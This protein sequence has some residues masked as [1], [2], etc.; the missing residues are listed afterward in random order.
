M[1]AWPV[2]G[3]DGAL[4]DAVV[5]VA[6]KRWRMNGRR[7]PALEED[8]LAA[9]RPQKGEAVVFLGAGLG[10]GVAAALRMGLPVAVVDK[11]AGLAEALGIRL[12]H[13]V[14]WCRHAD[15]EAVLAALTRWQMALGGPPLVPIVHPLYARLD[16]VFYRTLAEQLAASRNTRF[17]QRAR[18]PRL[19]GDTPRILLVASAYFLHGELLSAC[20]RLGYAVRAVELPSQEV[21]RQEFVEAIL[22]AV[23]E[24]RPHFALTVNHLGVDREGVLTDL[25]ARLELPLASWFVDDPHLIIGLYHSAVS[26]WVA[27]FTWDADTVESLRAMGFVHV[28]YLPLGTDPTRFVPQGT[29]RL[30]VAFVG[31]SMVHK[32]R[33]RQGILPRELASCIPQ[34]AEGFAQ[35]SLRTVRAYVAAHHPDILAHMEALSTESQ[36]ALETAIT[37]HATRDWRHACVRELLPFHPHIVGDSGWRRLLPARGWHYH[38]EM[39]YYSELPQ[40]YPQV[41]VN[42]NCTSLQMKGAVNQRVF[43]VPAC[44]AFLLTDYRRQMEDLFALGREV[45]CYSDPEEIDDLVRYYLSHDIPRQAVIQA[46]RKRVLLEHTYDA[47][48]ATLVAAMRQW[49]GG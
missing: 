14:L 46:A 49:Y 9:A 39:S 40:W 29:A 37:W 10:A 28:R 17:W 31:N 42:F 43:D 12:P 35:S 1:Q 16:P 32:T 27:L 33:T 48:L 34:V 2:R 8:L 5:E 22:Q 15:L 26:P 19:A 36:L 6:G 24:F 7:G 18:A 20:T 11:E 21:G 13:E 44:G 47:R 41:R 3:D 30:D 45:V 23:V 25:L 4:V 38:P